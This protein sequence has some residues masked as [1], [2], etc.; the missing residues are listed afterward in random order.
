MKRK[1]D[2]HKYKTVHDFRKDFLLIVQNAKLYNAPNT[3]YW[4]SAD[5]LEKYGIKTIDRIEKQIN[6]LIHQQQ[7]KQQQLSSSTSNQQYSW[8]QKQKHQ[9]IA[10]T[11]SSLR[12]DSI[13]V[14]EEEVDILGLDGPVRKSTNRVESE[15]TTREPSVDIQSSS[16][17]ITPIRQLKKKKKKKMSETGVIYGP[18][19]TL[20]A[21]GGGKHFIYL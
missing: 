17:A 11:S 12:K 3:I 21:V 9:K 18:D 14:K 13:V 2:H 1:I 19:G 16:R 10:V 5:K 6:D 15:V 20:H 7:R 4:K 8:Q